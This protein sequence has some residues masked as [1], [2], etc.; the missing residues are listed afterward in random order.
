MTS[1]LQGGKPGERKTRAG[2]GCTRVEAQLRGQTAVAQQLVKDVERPLVAGPHDHAALL[3]QVLRDLASHRAA[4]A[5]ELDFHVLAEARGVVVSDGLGVAESL[6]DGVGL[7]KFHFDLL[8]PLTA[9]RNARDVRHKNLGRLRFAGTGLAGHNHALIS[10]LLEKHPEGVIW[11]AKKCV[12]G[13]KPSRHGKRQGSV[14]LACDGVDVRLHFE[15]VLFVILLHSLLPV[16]PFDPLE[17]VHGHQLVA[18]VRIYLLLLESKEHVLHK[19]VFV[20]R[21]II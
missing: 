8:C 3:Q 13:G 5:V 11:K 21:R 10:T 9:A 16:Q 6:Q 7:E 17:G 20:D 15:Q 18:D 4:D 19:P 1:L 2:R 14:I 12:N